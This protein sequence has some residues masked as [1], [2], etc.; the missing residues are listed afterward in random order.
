MATSPEQHRQ[1]ADGID[2]DIPTITKTACLGR[3]GMPDKWRELWGI[4]VSKLDDTRTAMIVVSNLL[5][6]NSHRP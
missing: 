4:I 2:S 5:C 1:Q 6:I 3:M